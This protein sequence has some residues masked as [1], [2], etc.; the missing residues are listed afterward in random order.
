MPVHR[1]TDGP[2]TTLTLEGARLNALGGSMLADLR[3][4]LDAIAAEAETH[5]VILA[6]RGGTFC[7]G[8]DLTEIAAGDAADHA[9]L[10]A[11]CA[12]VMLRLRALPQPVI[13]RV[14]GNAVAAGCQ[15]VAACDLALAA[16]SARFGVNGVNIG[17]FCSTPLVALGRAI[18]PR[19]A[20]ELAV[21]GRL[22]DAAEALALGLITRAVP[23]DRLDAEVEA[24]AGTIATKLPAAVR[25]G[26]RAFHAQM[27]LAEP[28]A[29]AAATAAMLENL[30]D[31]DTRAGIAA[32]LEKRAPAG[33]SGPKYPGVSPKGE[34][35]RP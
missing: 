33:S 14:Q 34:G 23:P 27:A 24:L 15:L 10:F 26:K 2:V 9:D 3:T 12:A 21:T 30:D 31:P 13:A 22:I 19:A 25:L 17:L 32:F 4:H 29:Y 16:D 7:A 20:F 8:H 11:R 28:A 1:Q 6:A 35:Q 5:V 18:P